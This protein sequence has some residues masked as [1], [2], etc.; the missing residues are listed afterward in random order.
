MKISNIYHQGKFLNE[1]E[2]MPLEQCCS[3]CRSEN[4]KKVYT[5]QQ[6]PDVYLLE[7]LDCHA[8]SASRMPFKEVLDR[9]YGLYYDK[10][11]SKVTMGNINKFAK[12]IYYGFPQRFQGNASFSILDFGGGNG[13]ISYALAKEYLL[14]TYKHISISVVDYSE[15]RK[16]EVPE[17]SLKHYSSLSQID[18]EKFDLVL[19]SAILEHFPYPEPEMRK[20]FSLLKEKG[21]FYAR[22]PYV[23]PLMNL[24]KMLGMQLDFTYPGHLH[25][26]GP[27]FWDNIV[28]KLYPDF[29][30]KISKSR[31]SIVETSFDQNFIK[32]LLGHIFKF[33]WYFLRNF[34]GYVGGWEI[35][36]CKS[37]SIK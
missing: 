9:Y 6:V 23:L 15:T 7:C 30:L 20:L 14:K 25:D 29:N 18:S 5:L 27:K 2:L 31:P 12:H 36:I 24:L 32:A 35:F 21:L 4:R 26:L 11:T 19:A 17:I 8:V 13:S 3:F 37:N 33:P 22:T 28:H 1:N 16:S 34:Y 10:N